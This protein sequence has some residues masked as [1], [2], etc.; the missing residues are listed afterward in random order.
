M[1]TAAQKKLKSISYARYG[2]YFILPFFIVYFIFQM[3]PLVNTF[4]VSTTGNIHEKLGRNGMGVSAEEATFEK[5]VGLNNFEILLFGHSSYDGDGTE[6]AGVRG[7]R[8]LGETHQKLFFRDLKTTLILWI[9]N[10]IPQILLSLLLAVWF[11][12]AKIK[13]AGKGFFK[14]V[15]YMPNIIT[16]ASVAALYM[17]LFSDSADMVGPVNELLQKTHILDEGE[18]ISFVNQNAGIGASGKNNSPLYMV[19]FIQCW[20][21]FGNT[22]LM[23]MSGIMGINGSLFEAA[24]VDGANSWQAFTKITLPLLRPIMLYTLVTSMIGGLQMFDIPYIYHLGTNNNQDIET[25]AIYILKYYDSH[26]INS[27]AGLSGAASIILFVITSI[28]GAIAFYINRDKD[29]IAKNKQIKKLIKQKKSKE[30]KGFA[31]MGEV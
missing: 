13:I 17:K 10:F 4:V 8:N 23:L 1:A 28:L 30:T 19:M 9:G 2:Y 15:M 6:D 5:S 18:V 7:E 21:W 26:G 31:R 22:M 14:V 3:W 20:M 24:D 16:A 27:F 11:T 12:D 25:V 29:A